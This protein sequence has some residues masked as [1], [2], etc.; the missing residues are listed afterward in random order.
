MKTGTD[1]FHHG[2]QH[3]G[4]KIAAQQG[5]VEVGARGACGL[6]RN[7]EH[8]R[9]HPRT[10]TLND[11][12]PHIEHPTPMSKRIAAIILVIL[13]ALV[14]GTWMAIK[15][16]TDHLLYGKRHRGRPRMGGRPRRK[17]QGSGRDRQRRTA[18]KRQHG[19][20]RLRQA[21]RPSLSLHDLQSR[22]LFAARVGCQRHRAGRCLDFQSAARRRLWRHGRHWSTRKKENRQNTPSFIC[23]SL[24]ACDD[25]QQA[26]R[27]HRRGSRPDRSSA[28]ASTRR[29]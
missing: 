3:V 21:D 20:F 22:G 18:V 26:S 17:H 24:R 5:V 2:D 13:V 23:R 16:A 8:G 4:G 1:R 27:H 14:C 29:F 7:G 12:Q 15:L 25:R 28:T 6:A 9:T 11:S 19:V 10:M